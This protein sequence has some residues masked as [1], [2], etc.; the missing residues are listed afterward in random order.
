MTGLSKRR[1]VPTRGSLYFLFF[2]LAGTAATTLPVTAGENNV[3]I[4]AIINHPAVAVARARVCQSAS[5]YDVAVARERPQVDFSLRGGTS[6]KSRFEQRDANSP[7]SRRFDDEDIDAVIGI[8]Q[9]LFDWGGVDASKRVALSEQASNR[10][11]LSLEIDRVAADIIDLGIKLSEQQQRFDLFTQYKK[12]LAPHIRRI[13]AG[14]AVGVLR[15]SDLRSIK[16]IELDAD[17]AIT[18]AERQIAL[19]ENEL[20]QRFGLNPEDLAGLLA[21]FRLRLPPL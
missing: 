12:D 11:G 5:Q 14:V 6:L 13:E 17:I 15:L 19:L 21:T 16:V 3:A 2:I 10:I 20:G 1:R 7:H 18:L 8:N 4:D 9:L